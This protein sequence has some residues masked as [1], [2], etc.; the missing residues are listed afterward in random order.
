MP[1]EETRNAR[2][3]ALNR[4]ASARVLWLRRISGT[5]EAVNWIW[6]GVHGRAE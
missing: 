1:C 2:L 3:V 5:L 6:M 4:R